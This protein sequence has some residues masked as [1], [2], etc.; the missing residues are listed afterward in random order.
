MQSKTR[1]IVKLSVV[2]ALALVVAVLGLTGSLRVGKYRFYPFRDFLKPGLD[3]GGGVSAELSASEDTAQQAVDVLRARVSTLE[4]GGASV[5]L[6]GDGVRVDIPARSGAEELLSEV[7]ATGHVEL[8]DASGNVLLEGADIASAS[9]VTAYDDTGSGVPAVEFRVTDEAAQRLAESADELTGTTAYVYLDG[10]QVSTAGMDLVLEGGAGLIPVTDY[11]TY[12]EAEEAAQR[13]AAVMDAGELP[14]GVTLASTQSVSPLLGENAALMATIALCAAL[15]AA[16]LLLIVRYRMAGV[17]AALNLFVWA[18]AVVI[19]LCELPFARMT[20]SAAA[21]LLLGLGAMAGGS[22]LLLEQYADQYK[23]GHA[24]KIA[25]RRAYRASARAWLEGG[26]A[27]ALAGGLAY[28]LG[29]DAVRA[30]AVALLIASLSALALLLAL[31]RF[32][33]G[34]ALEICDATPAAALKA[35]RL[36]RRATG[37]ACAA[38]VVVALVL[39][40]CGAGL[41]GDASLSGGAVV[42]FALGEE[43]ALSDVEAAVRDAGI[44]GAQVIRTDATVEEASDDAT[45]DTAT[46]DTASDA[47]ADTATDDTASDATADT[48]TDDTA[49]DA[50][51]DAATDD[52]ASD[53]T[54]DTTTDETAADATADTATDDTASDATA[55]TAT[56]ETADDATADEAASGL[57]DVQIRVPADQA[58]ALCAALPA[59]EEALL[60]RYPAARLVSEQSAGAAYGS[61]VWVWALIALAVAC[62]GAAALLAIF[63]GVSGGLAALLGG[64]ASALMS[65]ALPCLAGWALRVDVSF[66]GAVLCCAVLSVLMSAQALDRLRELSRMPGKTRM[67][68]AQ[69]VQKAS[70]EVWRRALATGF[71][72]LVGAVCMLALGPGAAR[73]TGLAL[74]AGVLTSIAW[75][76]AFAGDVWARLGGRS[77][78]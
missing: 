69:I 6:L 4:L 64:V 55:D 12:A 23:Q 38:I 56:D 57:T 26:V 73:A 41:R 25:L 42:R 32:M 75:A 68:R 40:L 54:T 66:A 8:T 44:S 5:S 24:P 31:S 2:F 60:A 14:E 78:K 72:M 74:L 59:L 65:C 21:G 20:L 49:A 18:L 62:V 53:A 22:A 76:C 15:A 35:P 45:A 47:T 1:S 46:D 19:L 3:L 43:F 34:A 50:T 39:Q 9:A 48:A 29:S 61:D 67:P 52:T 10:A 17:A 77:G 33:T 13:L 51:T 28:W 71:P 30:F 7:C 27:L 58:E 70:P 36:L 63:H 37:I 16:A 11:A